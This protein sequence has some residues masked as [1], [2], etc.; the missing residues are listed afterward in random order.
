MLKYAEHVQSMNHAD[1]QRL[2]Q[3]LGEKT[4]EPEK[5]EGCLDARAIRPSKTAWKLQNLK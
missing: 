5:T 4:D 2:E 1:R 3:I